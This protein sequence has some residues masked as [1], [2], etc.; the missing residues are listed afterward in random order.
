[1]KKL[2]LLI[3]VAF[4]LLQ[5]LQAQ[6]IV[7][8]WYCP[9]SFLDSLGLNS[10]YEDTRGYFKFN[11]DGTFVLK[12]R[13]WQPMG[14]SWT[15]ATGEV[16][17][18]SWR[19]RAESKDVNVKI[20]GTY[21]IEDG[22]VTT[23][24]M[25]EGVKY[26][27]NADLADPDL[28]DA[29]GQSHEAKEGKRPG[30]SLA[31]SKARDRYR[32]MTYSNWLRGG[33]GV[34]E[35]QTRDRVAKYRDW[36]G[37]R[38]DLSQSSGDMHMEMALGNN[39]RLWEWNREPVEVTKDYI[40]VGGKY[41]L[42]RK[43]A[44]AAKRSRAD[45]EMSTAH[46][47]LRNGKG[48]P[49]RKREAARAVRKA[50]EADSLADDMYFLGHAYAGGYGVE[51]NMA[52]AVELLGKSAA[53]GN[54]EAFYELGMI[55]R[56]GRG[57]V[58]PDISKAYRCFRAGAEKNQRNSLYELGCMLTRGLG[59]EQSYE[60]ATR[61]FLPAANW[62]DAESLFMLG[63][64]LRNGYGLEKDSAL[65]ASCL[66]RA[67]RMH[68]REA[69]EELAREHEE[70]YMHEVYADSAKYAFIPDSVPEITPAAGAALAPGRYSGFIVTYDWSGAYILDER[71]LVMTVK[72]SADAPAGVLTVG[73]DTTSYSG[74]ATGGTLRFVSG[75]LT[76]P[77]RLAHG[78]KTAYRLD[79][80][81]MEEAGGRIRGR[82]NLYS[83]KRQ[84][85]GRPMYFE[86]RRM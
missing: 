61:A 19:K 50:V 32:A 11:K 79:S 21:S 9:Q 36:L 59:C 66:K 17:S 55:Y 71:P 54:K 63:V 31:L 76:L 78:G 67:A 22:K 74:T 81:A 45:D 4:G 38:R 83:P 27:V 84:E 6:S 33:R 72:E 53:K 69:A 70:T 57:G 47:L 68:C 42:T 20:S 80:M 64:F 58:K 24:V 16:P 75:G 26:D 15:L 73:T 43:C 46:M 28:A 35:A 37:D 23:R 14:S 40:L 34:S 5:P 18:N 56:W 52:K 8:K 60:A 41:K 25:P 13:G 2:L 30:G 86:L 85:P 77:D 39:S 3:T 65:A 10:F 82:L 7:G 12:L 44:K 62:P 1:M 49:G 48:S 51:R 29:G